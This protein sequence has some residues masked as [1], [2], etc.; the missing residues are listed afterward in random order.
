MLDAVMKACGRLAVGGDVPEYG[1]ARALPD[2]CGLLVIDNAEHL[3]AHVAEMVEA[4]LA[5][6]SQVRIVVASRERLR[7]SCERT[8]KVDP[9]ETPPAHSAQVDIL[10][11]AAV[12]LFLQRANVMPITV[13]ADDRQLQLVAEIC[14]RLDGI[15]LAIELAAARVAVLGLNGVRRCLDDRMAFLTCGYR[16]AP[17]RHQSL[18]AMYDWSYALLRDSERALFRRAAVFDDLFT[19]DAL[20]A[21]TCDATLS[22]DSVIEG[23]DAL[24]AKSL[25]NVHAEGP[26]VRYGLY[27]STRAYALQKLRDEGEAEAIRVRYERHILRLPWT[28]V[29]GRSSPKPDGAPPRHPAAVGHALTWASVRDSD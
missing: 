25:L 11:H 14:R 4:L 12:K 13:D 9:L 27:E 18:Q 6:N 8:F 24:V 29:G 23:V 19:L 5:T 26:R 21:V 16:N 20:C 1:I 10:S 17:P 7:I 2:L 15:P 3:I 22:P 28:A